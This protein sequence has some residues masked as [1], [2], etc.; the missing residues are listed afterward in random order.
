[1]SN[2]ASAKNASHNVTCHYEILQVPRNADA[3]LIKQQYRKLALQYHPDKNLNN[4]EEAQTH[5][6]LVQ[7]A[8][9]C[10]SDSTERKWYDEHRDAIL[11]GWSATTGNHN[12]KNADGSVSLVVNVIPFL[13]AGCYNGYTDRDGDFFAVYRQVFQDILQNEQQGWINQGHLDD[14][15]WLPKRHRHRGGSEDTTA[16]VD[17][18]T[19]T[20]EWTQ[21]STFYQI[22]Q[23]FS[24]CWNFAW[25]DEYQSQDGDERRLR[26]AMDDHNQKRRKLAKKEYNLTIMALVQFCQRRDPRVK[27][28][29]RNV[30]QERLRRQ[31][32]QQ[33][34]LVRKRQETQQAREE[35]KIQAAKELE[36]RDEEDRLAG[37]VRLA[38]L[39]DDYDYSG[40]SK[41]RGKKKKNKKQ[42]FSDGD[43]DDEEEEKEINVEAER[44]EQHQQDNADNEKEQDESNELGD[45]MAHEV[46]ESI[47]GDLN[48]ANVV[49]LV[50]DANEDNEDAPRSDDHDLSN[51]YPQQESQHDT[52]LGDDDDD[53]DEES[54]DE[55]W[56]C[57]CCRKDFKSEG[58][59]E[60]HAKSKKHKEA[61]KKYQAKL[62]KKE[63]EVMNDLLGELEIG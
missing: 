4:P 49:E 36:Q 20:T 41:K 27:A 15:P 54:I 57:E 37:R 17:F 45:A 9:E 13:H 35:W 61:F 52:V 12:N 16:V 3:A 43:D 21:V 44:N 25:A 19:S 26:R 40:R 29:E 7:Q 24:S 46:P 60:N 55:V 8:Y 18:G 38:D 28:Q 22:W 33:A 32:Q 39:D 11:Q 51:H 58:Q 42:Q 5:F 31:Q 10:L 53:E 30:E 48:K 1:M 62:K 2:P 56:R 34:E 47:N 50:A 23:G 59:L 6:R 14:L 63:E